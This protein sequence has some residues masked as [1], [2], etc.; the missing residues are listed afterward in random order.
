MSANLP[1][2]HAPIPC[3]PDEQLTIV[4]PAKMAKMITKVAA[5]APLVTAMDL[6]GAGSA[7]L[8]SGLDSCR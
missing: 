4:G 8:A 1:P 6:L 5:A 2:M 3:E 7:S